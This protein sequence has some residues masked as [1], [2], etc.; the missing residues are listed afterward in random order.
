MAM[1]DLRSAF[2]GALGQG[3]SVTSATMKSV[4]SEHGQLLRFT[5]LKPDGSPASFERTI[6][7]SSDPVLEAKQMAIDWL[8]DNGG[9]A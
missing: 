6:R 7:S 4:P 1:V 8:S 9:E 3:Y 2:G 5:F